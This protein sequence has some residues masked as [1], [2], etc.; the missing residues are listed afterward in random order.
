MRELKNTGSKF[1]KFHFYRY[2]INTSYLKRINGNF[3]IFIKNQSNDNIETYV[4]IEKQY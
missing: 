3:Y 2:V 4:C 1:A